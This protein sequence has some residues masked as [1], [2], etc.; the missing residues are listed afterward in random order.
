MPELQDGD[1]ARRLKVDGNDPAPTAAT[2][3]VTKMAVEPVWWLPGIAETL[4]QLSETEPAPHA[5][6]NR[7][8]AC[9]PSW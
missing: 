9:I 7:P 1:Q 2:S 6:S 3:K 8:A 4:R 5:C